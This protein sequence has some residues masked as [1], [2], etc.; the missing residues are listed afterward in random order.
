MRACW[1]LVLVWRWFRGRCTLGRV[2]LT[3]TTE[4]KARPSPSSPQ[5]LLV[6]A[7]GPSLYRCGVGVRVVQ[8]GETHFCK[9]RSL[10][11]VL[12]GHDDGAKAAR[13]LRLT[14]CSVLV[15]CSDGW[16]RT[17]QVC[18]TAQLLLDPHY[19]TLEGFCVLLEKEWL[20]FGHKVRC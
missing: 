8:H 19:R 10:F 3:V 11:A 12:R 5:R 16:D 1:R 9:S 13:L 18:S 15:H 7:L 4:F 14:G 20:S 17:P 2:V 6:T